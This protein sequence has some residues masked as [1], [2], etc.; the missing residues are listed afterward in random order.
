MCSDM[1]NSTDKKY[2]TQQGKV[3][4]T[5]TVNAD[6]IIFVGRV[7]DVLNWVTTVMAPYIYLH[8]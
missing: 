2:L 8:S 5:A 3:I 6:Q 1:T 4:R 7:I